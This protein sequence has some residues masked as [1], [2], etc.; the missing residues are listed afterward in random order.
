M[1]K[2]LTKNIDSKRGP[3]DLQGYEQAGGYAAVRK[4]LSDMAPGEVTELQGAKISSTC[5]PA[6]GGT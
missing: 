5:S 2:P 6:V 3:L 4:V 1:E